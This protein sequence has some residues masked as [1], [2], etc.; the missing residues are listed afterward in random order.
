MKIRKGYDGSRHAPSSEVASNVKK[1][2]HRKEDNFAAR[3]GGIVIKGIQKPDVVKGD[4]RIS[5]KGAEANIQ[6][7]LLSIKK[8]VDVYGRDSLMYKYQFSGYEHRK[9]KLDNENY[10]NEDLFEKYMKNAHK[11]AEWLRNKDNFKKIVEKV[12]SDNYDANKLAIMKDNNGNWESEDAYLYDMKDVINLYINSN[13]RIHVTDGAKIVVRADNREIF[14]LEI[15]GGKHH[16]GSM[17]H[18]VRTSLY[19][20]L[21]NNLKYEVIS[22]LID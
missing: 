17:N 2:G 3:Y 19:D 21:K 4:E 11:I 13:Y 12:F 7:Y 18:G 15:R 1:R 20:F 9:F 8:S 6:L 14:Y 5:I 16:C 10:V 22:P